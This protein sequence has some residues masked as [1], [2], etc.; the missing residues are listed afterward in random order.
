M[1]QRETYQQL[2]WCKFDLLEPKNIDM[3]V[4][5]M[6][7]LEPAQG[8]SHLVRSCQKSG[9]LQCVSARP[10]R[11]SVAGIHNQQTARNTSRIQEAYVQ[12]IT[13]II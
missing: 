8:H 10:T 12:R 6:W 3:F 4:E 9:I 1:S 5:T 7:S 11:H 13:G 2:Q